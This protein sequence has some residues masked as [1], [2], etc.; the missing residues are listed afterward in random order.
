MYST[1]NHSEKRSSKLNSG[2]I[3]QYKPT[4]YEEKLKA[5]I[6]AER[7][8]HKIQKHHMKALNH[9]KIKSRANLLRNESKELK[10]K[11]IENE[12]NS[13]KANMVKTS[14]AK[15]QNRVLKPMNMQRHEI[16]R[17]NH[18]NDEKT[19]EFL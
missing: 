2:R 16:I 11:K 6:K 7:S 10:L 12:F 8:I 19:Q 1:L 13:I 14:I 9:E 15:F 3:S 4:K 5:A 18:R 17:N